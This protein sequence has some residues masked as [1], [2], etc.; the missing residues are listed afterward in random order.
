MQIF[1]GHVEITYYTLL[2]MALYAAWRLAYAV[3]RKPYTVNRE[4]NVEHTEHGTRNTEHGTRNTAHGLRDTFLKPIIWLSGMVL[5]GLLLGAVQL[6]PLFEVGQMNFREGSASFEEVRGWAFPARRILTLALPNFFGNPAYHSYQDVF[7]GEQVAY[8]ADYFGNPRTHNE[9]DFKNY[10]EGAIY[11]GILPLL[12]AIFGFRISD[13]GFRS[14]ERRSQTFFFVVITFFSLA[15]IFG[16]PLYA[17]LYYGLPFINQLHT[18]FRWIFPLT[19]CVAA[20]AGFG[21]DYLALTRERKIEDQR[22]ASSSQ[23]S[24]FNLQSLFFLRTRPSLITFLAA[25]A[26]WGGLLLLGGLWASK[27]FYA[28]I[29]PFVERAFLSLALATNGFDSTP[30]RFIALNIASF[31]SWG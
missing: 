19:L 26:F 17:I 24:T 6:V 21:A 13:F 9:W 25:V 14:G 1:A 2:L 11:L 15:F 20:L 3:F 10:V 27:L 28:R 16:T 5:I 22:W 7:T 31:S 29:E 23:S 12:L 18:P 4:R 8:T 30:E